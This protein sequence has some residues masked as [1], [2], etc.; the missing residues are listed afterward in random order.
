MGKVGFAGPYDCLWGILRLGTDFF[1]GCCPDVEG[2][3]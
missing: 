3:G 1:L 2:A